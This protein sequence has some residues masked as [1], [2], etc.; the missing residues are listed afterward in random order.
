EYTVPRST[1][2][3]GDGEFTIE[4]WNASGFDRIECA[5]RA[6]VAAE[7]DGSSAAGS[8]QRRGG[9]ETCRGCDR[10]AKA[11]AN[12]FVVNQ[13]RVYRRRRGGAGNGGSAFSSQSGPGT[14]LGPLKF[15][16]ARLRLRRSFEIIRNHIL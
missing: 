6:A 10:A 15:H 8:G 9:I 13:V 1:G 7:R 4:W 5:E 11:T 12:S 16:F 3:S 14:R 2:Q